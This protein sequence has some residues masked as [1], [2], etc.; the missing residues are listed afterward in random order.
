[1]I[2]ENVEW[3][4]LEKGFDER[5]VDYLAHLSSLEN[6]T[7]AR[8]A[9][10]SLLFF[11]DKELSEEEKKVLENPK[12]KILIR[13]I[14][15][16]YLLLL[17]NIPS[18]RKQ[19]EELPEYRNDDLKSLEAL[20][21]IGYLLY[22]CPCKEELSLLKEFNKKDLKELLDYASVNEFQDYNYF[23]LK[24]IKNDK[25][26][27]LNEIYKMKIYFNL[28]LKE[29]SENERNTLLEYIERSFQED[30]K[31]KQAEFLLTLST[32]K[33]RE[34]VN[35]GKLDVYDLD[36]D[37]MSN[38]FERF[39]FTLAD[40]LV[41]NDR[42]VIVVYAHRPGIDPDDAVKLKCQKYYWFCFDEDCKI[43]YT[44]EEAKK[45]LVSFFTEKEKIPEENIWILFGKECRIEELDKIFD[46][47]LANSD[48]NDFIY[49]LFVS[50][51]GGKEN[52]SGFE[53]FP[54]RTIVRYDW[55]DKKLDKTKYRA[56]GLIFDSCYSGSAFKYLQ[57]ENRV[58][59]SSA[60]PNEKSYHIPYGWLFI[61]SAFGKNYPEEPLSFYKIYRDARMENKN[62][63]K[64]F[65]KFK[66]W[67]KKHGVSYNPQIS[68]PSNISKRL[69]LG[70]YVVP[71]VVKP[72]KWYP[73]VFVDQYD[74]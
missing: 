65:E 17:E 9:A 3:Y 51:G 44:S 2:P 45:K 23:L 68:D 42:Y 1:M 19:I 29:L 6:Q 10:K 50:H 31:Y 5:T 13:K 58:I 59:L 39:R 11:G 7:L 30:K 24:S 63:T 34:L 66:T 18:L 32:E 67:V 71:N 16:K 47:I 4:I 12:D 62:F 55:V 21:D 54:L 37:G 61:A 53:I 70:E 43:I 28:S 74:L 36:E 26:R 60:P 69:Y 57:G 14:K 56:A 27:R 20:E 35:S 73:F 49:F 64:L 22:S 33:L 40:P 48:E 38:W 8:Y 41:H 72:I 46:D 52:S 25:Y 15:E